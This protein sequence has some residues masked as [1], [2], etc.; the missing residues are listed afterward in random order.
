[1]PPFQSKKFRPSTTAASSL[2]ERLGAR[3]RAN[4]SRHPFLLFGLPFVSVMV[5][6]SF[7]LTP[8]TALRYERHDR[9]VQQLGKEEAM[10]LGLRGAD[11]DASQVRRNPRRR[12]L[13]DERE[14]YYKLM[15]KDLDSWEQKRVQRFKGEPDGRLA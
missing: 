15:A 7:F 9:R 3:Y 4:L 13:G 8:A 6:G 10:A 11:E 5:A 12:I 2:G 1:M 14:E